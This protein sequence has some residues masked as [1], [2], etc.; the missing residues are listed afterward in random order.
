MPELTHESLVELGFEPG[1]PAGAPFSGPGVP[2]LPADSAGSLRREARSQHGTCHAQLG[3]AFC[4]FAARLLT[5]YPPQ[6]ISSGW[7]AEDRDMKACGAQGEQSRSE[8]LDDRALARLKYLGR[9][10]EHAG[11]ETAADLSPGQVGLGQDSTPM[12]TQDLHPCCPL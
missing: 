12:M 8:M 7:R 3:A 2:S 10:G 9:P 4:P 6:A 5:L 1:C 11:A